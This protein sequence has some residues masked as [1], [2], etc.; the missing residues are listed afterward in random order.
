MVRLPFFL[1][2]HLIHAS[3]TAHADAYEK[4]KFIHCDISSGNLLILPSLV[5]VSGEA[6]LRVVWTGILGDWELATAAVGSMA[7]ERRGRMVSIR[8]IGFNTALT[9]VTGH[10]PLCAFGIAPRPAP[11]CQHSGRDRVVF[12]RHPLKRPPVPA[13]QHGP[14]AYDLDPTLLRRLRQGLRP[15][16]HWRMGEN[17]LLR[18]RLSRVLRRRTDSHFWTRRRAPTQFDSQIYAFMFSFT[19][20]D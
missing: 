8:T 11:C 5:S 16:S 18:L 4:C 2:R 20:K 15:Y 12:R 17:V 3:E 1:L 6:A 9:N 13:A 10:H 14:R 19:L 7:T